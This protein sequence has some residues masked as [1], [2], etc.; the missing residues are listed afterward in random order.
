M[1]TKYIPIR[2]NRLI[3]FLCF[4]L[5]IFI[6]FIYITTRCG[7]P[8]K[9]LPQ[10]VYFQ[11]G[12]IIL[13]G[14]STF[15][16]RILRFLRR[17]EEWAHVGLLTTNGNIEI[18]HADPEKGVIK[19]TLSEYLITNNVDA[20]ALLRTTK[21]GSLDAISYAEQLVNDNAPFN[22]SF[23]YKSDEGVYCTELVLLAWENAG[24][25]LLPTARYGDRIP[26]SKLFQSS[27]LKCIWQLRTKLINT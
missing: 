6:I 2:K 10:G 20:I 12:D 9:Q 17:G 23:R 14:S 11:N 7:S 24:V 19:Q 16:G 18:I 4:F 26:P 27:K 13:L 8:I 5:I 15:R 21:N 3:I 25:V 1:T 22:H